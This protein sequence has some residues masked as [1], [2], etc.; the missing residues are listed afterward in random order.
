MYIDC[1]DMAD[2]LGANRI[3][4]LQYLCANS[5]QL[6][7]YGMSNGVG[8]MVTSVQSAAAGT[9]IDALRIWGH[10]YPGGQIVSGGADGSSVDLNFAGISLSN[11]DQTSGV[12]AQLTSLFSANGRAELRGCS[13]GAD[14]AGRALLL[15]LASLWGVPVYGADVVQ[16][17]GQWNPPVTCAMPGGGLSTT[18]GPPVVDGNT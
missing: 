10:G 5:T 9:P 3:Q 17:T 1:I 16:T 18:S 13:V 8:Q 14:G 15:D 4:W 12:L 11:F 7:F 2:G 6:Q